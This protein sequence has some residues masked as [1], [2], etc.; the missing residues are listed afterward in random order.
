[1]REAEDQDAQLRDESKRSRNRVRTKL[2]TVYSW[3]KGYREYDKDARP[4]KLAN[5]TVD[6]SREEILQAGK[7]KVADAI[8]KLFVNRTDDYAEQ[9]PDGKYRRVG[10][11]L[12]REDID[13]HL[14]YEKTIGV[15][16]INPQDQTVKWICWDIDVIDPVRVKELIQ[17]ILKRIKEHHLEVAASLIEFSGRKGYHLWLF[18]NPPIVAALAYRMGRKIADEAG[19]TG[20]VFPKQRELLTGYGNLVK[21]PLGKHQVTQQPS[22]FLDENLTSLN[23]NRIHSVQPEFIYLT[24]EIR[25]EISEESRPWMD[26]VGANVDSEPYVG[27][28][29]PCILTLLNQAQKPG[30]RRPIM[31]ILGAY[32]LNFRGK[33]EDPEQVAEARRRLELWNAGNTP[34]LTSDE[35]EPQ[36]Q[37]LISTPQYNYGCHNEWLSRTCAV[38]QC[39]LMR[40]KISILF[41]DFTREEQAAGEKILQGDIHGGFIQV[42]NPWV[43]RDQSH[44]RNLLRTC[45]SAFCEHPI[46]EAL[47]GRD[48]IG[49]THVSVNSARALDMK[50]RYLW[51]LGGVSPTALIHDYSEYDKTRGARII[52]LSGTVLLFLEPPHPE[53]WA[54]L[55][56]ILSHDKEEIWF[57]I[58]DRTKGGQLRTVKSIIKG[59]PA[60]I[61]CA[62]VSGYKGGEYSARFLTSTPEISRDK[63]RE[64]SGKTARKYEKPW[65]YMYDKAELRAW[66]AAY[67]ILHRMMPI[68]VAIPYAQLLH[69]HLIIRGPE[70]M[71]IFDYF[72][73]LIIANAAL[74]CRQRQVDERG[75]INATIE[76]LKSVHDDFKAIATTTYLGI[77]NDA[78]CLHRQ[79]AGKT[80]LTFED[81][82]NAAR[83]AFGADTAEHTLRELYVKR[84]VEVGL[85]REKADSEDK[86]RKRYD[87]DQKTPEMS[88]FDDFDALLLEVTNSTGAGGTFE[89]S[90][91]TRNVP[92]PPVLLS[93][94]QGGSDEPNLGGLQPEKASR[95]VEEGA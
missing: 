3:L 30:T 76:D 20:E 52:N 63:T 65:E 92:P 36:W 62:A 71:R 27:D 91:E 40:S 10:R 47:F 58:T 1:M 12:T 19:F 59:W 8:W 79:I 86:R 35:F 89:D 9:Q 93:G 90:T 38:T 33:R 74:Y 61:Q 16:A 66:N 64:G 31:H 24:D 45:V 57:R 83:E 49:K 44:R 94:A 2:A 67:D 68:R 26:V 43:A 13:A 22:F 73:R 46:N 60:V 5:M 88:I 84:L 14:A 54:R 80:D 37:S 85:L 56:P 50:G 87:A 55:K 51:Y 77:S 15:Y 69:K 39:P 78:L 42:T 7:R 11:A 41:G 95:Q 4:I 17:G 70:T 23:E 6:L 25:R 34:P 72:C 21:I 53:T 32:L 75:Y 48:S 81:I 29:P 18:F 82:A 28:D